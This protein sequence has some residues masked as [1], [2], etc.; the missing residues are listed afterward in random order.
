MN[1]FF[2]TISGIGL[3]VFAI[4]PKD[5]TITTKV[6]N[7]NL[8]IV[9]A[10]SLIFHGF[11][12]YIPHCYPLNSKLDIIFSLMLIVLIFFL[13]NRKYKPLVF[14]SFL[15][16][17]FPDLIDLSPQI[18]SKYLNIT[19]LNHTFV[20]PWHWQKY[21]G[22]IFNSDC[23]ISNINHLLLV[24]FILCILIIEKEKLKE[25]FN[26]NQINHGSDN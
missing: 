14:Y 3:T 18:L 16:S 20:F 8:F 21:S 15:G 4:T 10:L 5:N 23:T 6:S 22:S 17:I 9:F 2:H 13:I 19:F 25:L 24:S 1:V 11:L 7:L 26:K 12:D